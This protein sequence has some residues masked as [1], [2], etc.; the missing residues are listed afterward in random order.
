MI[1]FS[2][3]RYKNFLATGNEFTEIDFN[4]HK[5][6]LIV[7]E[8]GSGKST[9]LEAL[10]YGLYNKAFRKINK[11]Q[12]V[13]TITQRNTLVEV[14]FKVGGNQ[15]LVRRGM[16]PE[17]FEIFVND[18][19]IPQDAANRDYQKHLETNILKMNHK[20]FNQIVILGKANFIPFM[21]LSAWD[22]RN[23][24]EDLLDIQVFSVM[25]TLLKDIVSQN[26]QDISDCDH[27]ISLLT[28]KLELNEQHIQQLKSN[29]TDAIKVKQ[30]QIQK[31]LKEN[32]GYKQQIV[33]FKEKIE[34]NQDKLGKLD[35][36]N[37]TLNKIS[38]A[39]N[40]C[41]NK[42]KRLEKDIS[43]Y[44]N[45]DNCP[46]CKQ[47]IGV[48]HKTQMVEKR[49]AT[50]KEIDSAILDLQQRR[51]GVLEKISKYSLVKQDQEQLKSSLT[52]AEVSSNNNKRFIAALE[53]EILDLGKKLE[54]YH[55]EGR[56]ELKSELDECETKRAQLYADRDIHSI[57]SQLLKDGGIK[58]RII[59]Q[60]IPVINKLINKYLLILDFF[61]DFSLNEEFEEKIMSRFRDE[62]SYESFSEGEKLRIDLG[63]LFAWRALAKMRNSSST[64]LLIMDEIFDGSLD[65]NGTEGFMK[66]LDSLTSETNVFIISH[67]TD[68]ISDK[69]EEILR[70]EKVKHFSKLVKG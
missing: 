39:K 51:D 29:T 60:Y 11:P 24:I 41:D 30:T 67:K 66:L 49:Q 42:I 57:A 70:F 54:G 40:E 44:H 22:R 23:I 31:L 45:S 18:E 58:T 1:L 33:Q 65:Y 38:S 64:N 68:V 8:N 59:K 34:D 46:T 43:F 61:V 13:N 15:Y 53:S 27:K 19:L 63:L 5:L 2:K 20:S 16:K 10:S 12:L 26:K 37:V 62:F 47:D 21:K 6:T 50:I 52:T 25:N 4:R 14:E 69:F 56:L 55:V 7:G 28:S 3:L 35:K 9:V 17:I 48:D 32:E 36:L